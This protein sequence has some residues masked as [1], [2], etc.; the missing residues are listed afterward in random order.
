MANACRSHLPQWVYAAD[1][2]VIQQP[3]TSHLSSPI[4]LHIP[5][6]STFH[7]A[8]WMHCNAIGL[9]T[10]AYTPQAA[11]NAPFLPL[12][13]GNFCLSFRTQD[14]SIPV[15][16]PM[17]LSIS[18]FRCK[19]RCGCRYSYTQTQKHIY[20]H[21][22]YCVYGTINGVW[23]GTGLRS[24]KVTSSGKSSLITLQTRSSALL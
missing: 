14:M 7:T 15:S 16:M 13:L 20:T 2:L 10:C 6:A 1:S 9:R 3:L 18:S 21:S 8:P 19:Q 4:S 11:R 24:F 5:I 22:I 17:S 12:C 23:R